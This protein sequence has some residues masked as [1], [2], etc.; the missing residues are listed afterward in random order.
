[1]R[2]AAAAPT[3]GATSA[4]G[5]A[6]GQRCA[7]ASGSCASQ[8]HTATA[9]LAEKAQE[10]PGYAAFKAGQHRIQPNAAVVASWQFA[11]QFCERY[12]QKPCPVSMSTAL[13]LQSLTEGVH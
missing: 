2:A 12:S 5:T 10:E 9:W 6:H 8:S 4:L 7:T 13:S 3:P 1:M 11:V